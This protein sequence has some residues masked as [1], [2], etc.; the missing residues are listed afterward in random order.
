M[1]AKRSLRY[2]YISVVVP[3]VERGLRLMTFCSMAIAGGMPLMKSHSGLFLR[4]RN[5]LAY[6]DRLSTYLR[7]PS[8]YS[9]SKAKEDLP[10]PLTP[11]TTI[12]LLRGILM[13]MF[14]RLLTRAPLISMYSLII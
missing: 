11:V 4:P 1:R 7:W 12:N 14:F 10:E 9:V 13:S 8:A 3:T 2:S 6:A 5:C